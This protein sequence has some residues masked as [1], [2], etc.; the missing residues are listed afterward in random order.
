MNLV[1]VESPAK[2]RTIEK[3]LGSDYKVAASFGHVRDLPEKELGVDT[4]HNFQPHYIIPFKARKTISFLKSQLKNADNVYLAT[5]FDREG[6]AIAWHVVQALGLNET[7]DQKSKIKN[8]HRITFHEI[9]KDA[10]Q[11]AIKHPREIDMDL[12]D[13]QQARRVLDRL[14]GYKL[15]P[16]LWRKIY[17]GLSAGRVQS[18]AV[19]LIVEREREIQKFKPEEY[20]TIAAELQNQKSKIKNQKFI[21]TLNGIDDKKIDKLDIK[22]EKE[23]RKIINDLEKADYKVK[24]IEEKSENRWPYPPFTTSTMQQ[25]SSKKLG[26]SAKKTMKLAQDLYEAGHITYMRTDSVNLSQLAINTA[27]KVVEDNFGKSYLP[28][29]AK[30]YKTKT[31]GAQEAHEAIRPTHLAN[32]ISHIANSEFNDDHLKLYDLI[33]KR[34]VACQ[35]KEAILDT[36]AV[37]ILAQKYTFRANGTKVKFAGFMKVWP[38]KLEEKTLPQLKINDICDLISLNK[39]QHFTEPPARYSEASL[40]KALEEHGIGRPSTY[41]PIISTIQDRKYV[42]LEQRYFRPN[43]IGF[44]VTDLL[45]THFPNIVDIGFTAKMED[46]F[47]DVSEGKKDWE[48]IISDFYHPFEKNLGIKYK[49]VEKKNIVEEKTDRKCPKCD[50]GL[51]IKLGRF[52]RFLACQGFP[53][54]KYTE[55]IINKIGMKC[56]DCKEGDIIERQTKRGK[57]FW[58]CSR[59]PKC[60]WGSWDDPKKMQNANIKVQNENVKF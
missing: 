37:D 39:D 36:L 13:A 58:G 52:G 19:R 60:H 16:F 51:V 34:M 14:V 45:I 59:Y 10:I 17:S 53:E 8:I 23:A 54:C 47:D 42:A 49:E 12:V 48:K 20:W 18:V 30:Y 7:K 6:E 32:R 9:T 56:P 33:W 11:E 38:T 1:I 4:E 55:Q 25:E 41:A 31:K 28:E 3:Y 46:E 44:L 26:F 50:K 29:K 22:S 2:G 21:A 27:R 40:I 57:K 5:D 15:S 35:M 43:E 24:N